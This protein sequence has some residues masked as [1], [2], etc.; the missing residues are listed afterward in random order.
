MSL[1]EFPIKYFY[2]RF[3]KLAAIHSIKLD[4]VAP[5]FVF[6]RAAAVEAVPQPVNA[7][8]LANGFIGEAVIRASDLRIVV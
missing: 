3:A 8:D 7:S 1:A 4:L 2:R 6:A 5:D